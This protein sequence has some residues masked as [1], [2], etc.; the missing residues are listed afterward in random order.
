MGTCVSTGAI[1]E[2]DVA[3]RFETYKDTGGS[4]RWRL[5]DGNNVKVASSGEAF[6]SKW[7]ARRAAQNVK[8]TAPI[9]DIEDD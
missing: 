6:D 1:T 7:N 4:W 5:I 3:A 9:A 2:V 8:D